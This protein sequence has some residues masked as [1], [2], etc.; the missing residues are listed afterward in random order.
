MFGG[1]KSQRKVALNILSKIFY[2]KI[3]LSEIQIIRG[4]ASLQYGTQFGGLINF[5]L[6]SP[7]PNKIEIRKSKILNVS[8]FDWRF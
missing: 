8:I 2:T 6:R 4:A 3:S 5:K 7:N 1:L